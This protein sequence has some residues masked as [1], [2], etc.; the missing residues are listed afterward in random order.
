MISSYI[1][2]DSR[3]KVQT[4]DFNTKVK[5]IAVKTE[6]LSGREIAKLGVAWQV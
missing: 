2:Y 3:L 4:M 5:E 1:S 6:G